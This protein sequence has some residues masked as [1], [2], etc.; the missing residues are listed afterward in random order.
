MAKAVGWPYENLVRIRDAGIKYRQAETSGSD[1]AE[2]F[3][4]KVLAYA[5]ES[6]NQVTGALDRLDVDPLPHQIDLVHRI[7]NSD[8]SNWLIADDVGLGKT[9]EV[10]LLL[11]AMKRRQQA[12]RVLVVCPAGVVRQWQ[13]E[14]RYKFD[15]D[16]RIYG[17]DFNINQPSHWTSYEKVIVIRRPCKN[18]YSQLYIW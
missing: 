17:L 14:M 8:H 6:W 10:G 16:F 3:R 5:L 1:N 15:E 18:G 7:M 4:L 2:K 9:I 12:R 13:D 11:K